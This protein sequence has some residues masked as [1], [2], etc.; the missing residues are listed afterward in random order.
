MVLIL[1]NGA[2]ALNQQLSSHKNTS[3]NGYCVAA[4]INRLHPRTHWCAYQNAS[5]IQTN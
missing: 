5:G 1:K 2:Q 3:H 4:A